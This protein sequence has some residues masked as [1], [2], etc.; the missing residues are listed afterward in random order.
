LAAQQAIVDDGVLIPLYHDV[1]YILIKPWVRGL[2][3]SPVG[4]LG[5]EGVWIEN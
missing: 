5:L 1:N 4:M 2:V 3:V